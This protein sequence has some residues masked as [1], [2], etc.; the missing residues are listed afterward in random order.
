[1]ATCQP[2][3]WKR[4]AFETETKPDEELARSSR[5]EAEAIQK[6]R[7]TV[8]QRTENM[9]GSQWSSQAGEGLTL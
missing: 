2:S 9:L 4:H 6:W 1:M 5:L 8:N 7:M 3:N